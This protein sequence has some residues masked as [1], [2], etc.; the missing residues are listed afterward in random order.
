[1]DEEHERWQKR[2]LSPRRYVYVWA[3]GIRLRARLKE[4]EQ[5]C[6]VHKTANVLNK[7]PK[8]REYRDFRATC[9]IGKFAAHGSKSPVEMSFR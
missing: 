1:M 6:W 9:H 2:D 7:L 5:R 4:R 8:D 3:D